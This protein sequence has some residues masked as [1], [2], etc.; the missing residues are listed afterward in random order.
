MTQKCT[1]LKPFQDILMKI[2]VQI[3]MHNNSVLGKIEKK[4]PN[5]RL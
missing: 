1:T 5:W 3:I 4:K 2:I